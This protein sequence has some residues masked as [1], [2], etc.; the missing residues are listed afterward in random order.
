MVHL[1]SILRTFFAFLLMSPAAMGGVAIPGPQDDLGRLMTS[2]FTS[3]KDLAQSCDSGRSYRVSLNPASHLPG[4]RSGQVYGAT[5]CGHLP[6]PYHELKE[7]FSESGGVYGALSRVQTFGEM[8]LLDEIN[9]AS[10]YQFEIV[11]PLLSNYRVKAWMKPEV[12]PELSVLHWYQ[13][14][15]SSQ[16]LNNRGFMVFVP[17]GDGTKVYL[18]AYHILKENHRLRF[19]AT[20]FA[21][22]FTR[23]HYSNY[24]LAVL[25]Y[26]DE[27]LP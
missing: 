24:F 4:Y 26:A 15:D 20:Q 14:D 2:T 25:S 1:N 23:D 8:N 27:L 18:S 12:S 22:G 9:G 7:L 16:L 19:P 21:P 17:V 6:Y 3:A 11:V 5:V 13:E 10:Y